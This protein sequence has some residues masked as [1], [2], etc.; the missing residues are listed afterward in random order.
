MEDFNKFQPGEEALQEIR[1]R[2]LSPTTP[3]I[4]ADQPIDTIAPTIEQRNGRK[5]KG[6]KSLPKFNS[7]EYRIPDD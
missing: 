4:T 1:K 6:T 5:S 7:S 3:K 2:Y